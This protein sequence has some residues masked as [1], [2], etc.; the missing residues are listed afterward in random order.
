MRANLHLHSR[1]SDGT[2]WPE[3]LA[4][5][6]LDARLEYVSLTDHDSMAGVPDFL[7]AAE[8]LGLLAVPGCE[9]DCAAP[10]IGYRSEILAYF[11]GGSSSN[12]EILLQQ[13]CRKR[14]ERVRAYVEGA[15]RAFRREELSFE[16]LLDFKYGGGKKRIE[17]KG[18]S[19]SKVDFFLYLR[20]KDVIDPG[21]DYREFR[22]SWLDSGLIEGPKA[23]RSTV[24]EIVAAVRKD[25]GHLV[26]PHIGHE[27]D[28]SAEVLIEERKRLRDILGYFRELGVEGVELYWYRNSSTARINREVAREAGRLGFFLSYGSD[29]HGPGSGKHTIADFSGDFKGFP[30][31]QHKE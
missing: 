12:T 3:E 30:P 25:G 18:A 9:I 8:K 13:L 17:G 24:G 11:P 14:Q 28:D 5:A 31:R 2:L 15:R 1:Y 6:A 4:A 23:R 20:K 27:F 22:K 26:I 29:C 16:E 21:V 7:A 19:L 10:E